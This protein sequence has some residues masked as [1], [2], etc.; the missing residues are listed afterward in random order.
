MDINVLPF[1]SKLKY[2]FDIRYLR[3]YGQSKCNLW[4]ITGL[5]AELNLKFH[6]TIHSQFQYKFLHL[7]Y[8]DIYK[9]VQNYFEPYLL[10]HHALTF[11]VMEESHGNVVFAWI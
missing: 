6:L 9:F 11:Y 7:F 3:R 1:L 2:L 10:P 8:K 5:H 4:T